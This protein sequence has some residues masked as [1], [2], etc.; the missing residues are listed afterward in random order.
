MLD[1]YI[2]MCPRQSRQQQQ[3]DSAQRH[4]H[5]LNDQ[6]QVFLSFMQFGPSLKT[7]LIGRW[8]IGWVNQFLFRNDSF[9]GMF[10]I[11][12]NIKWL[13]HG[14]YIMKVKM[15]KTGIIEL[16]GWW[17]I[18]FGF[19]TSG[20][21]DYLSPEAIQFLVWLKVGP[22]LTQID[23]SF[24]RLD[25][26]LRPLDEISCLEILILDNC[27]LTDQHQL[28]AIPSLRTLRYLMGI[29]AKI[30]IGI[31]QVLR[32]GTKTTWLLR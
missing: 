2:W 26:D 9:N 25:L 10:L 13:Q 21:N 11:L 17:H 6:K 23:L 31:C 8:W 7:Y 18:F 24:S 30:F 5:K 19:V 27:S 16:A 4:A 29:S 22:T 32:I 1:F 28:P 14:N 3:L 15:Y 12:F 20:N